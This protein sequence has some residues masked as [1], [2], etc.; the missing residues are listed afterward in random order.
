VVEDASLAARLP[1]LVKEL[2]ADRKRLSE[3][4]TA[5]C[6]LARPQ[7]ARALAGLI[8]EL[9]GGTGRKVGQA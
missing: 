1:G 9:A 3:M 4:S 8:R 2:L 6:A 7:A 5:L